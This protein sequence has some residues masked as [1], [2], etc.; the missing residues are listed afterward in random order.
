MASPPK[1]H[2]IFDHATWA[3]LCALV[4]GEDTSFL[5]SLFQN[6]LDAASQN[7]ETLRHGTDAA[8]KRRAAHTLLGSSLSVGV[9][10]VA[11]MCRKLELELG[12]IPV[13]DLVERLAKIETQLRQV[14]EHYPKALAE[15]TSSKAT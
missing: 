15:V 13:S 9:P 3:Q 5:E 14:E 6:Y 4:E 2:N 11:V 10:S 12:R 1:P 7:L 8:D